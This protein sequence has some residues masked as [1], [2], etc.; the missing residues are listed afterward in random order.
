[1]TPPTMLVTGASDGIGLQT[2]MQLGQHGARVLVH[3][4]TE[5]KAR[6]VVKRL[7]AHGVKEAIPVWADLSVIA[8]VK[9]LAQQVATHTTVLDVLVNNAGVFMTEAQR[10]VD[11]FEMTFAVNHF[12]PFLLTHA[13]LPMLE[14]AAAA[15]IV[16]VSSVAHTRG[17][18]TVEDLPVPRDFDGYAAYGASK[19]LNVLF[20]H[21]LARRLSAAQRK[22]VTFALHP[23]VITTKLLKTGFG[24]AGASVESGA[25]TSVFCAT[26]KS[27]GASGT[28]YSDAREVPCAPTANDPA[29]EKAVYERSCA[30]VGCDPL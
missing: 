17:R 20:T 5:T 29:L 26:S 16:N 10:S 14:A 4:R 2:A 30:L 22:P 18:V 24:M 8:Q 23:G 7:D 9:A 15:R 12:A 28:Y 21:E 13:V 19:L 11:G 27:V 1:M 3:A 6:D 25:R